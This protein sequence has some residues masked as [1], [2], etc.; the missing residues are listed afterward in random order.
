[1]ASTAT[2]LWDAPGA[3]VVRVDHLDTDSFTRSVDR[4]ANK[5]RRASRFANTA[6][7]VKGMYAVRSE[8]RACV[9]VVAY[10]T[11]FDKAQ[12]LCEA[13]LASGEL[14][15]GTLVPVDC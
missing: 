13:W 4:A 1:M 15:P 14:E 10:G 12:A 2:V 5:E 7:Y 9:S 11:S 3:I 6:T 8:G